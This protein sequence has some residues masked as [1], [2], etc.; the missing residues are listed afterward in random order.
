MAEKRQESGF[1]VTDRRL[2]TED[3]ELRKDVSEEAEAPKASAS[4]ASVPAP[5]EAAPA[6]SSVAPFPAQVDG[7]AERDMPLP[8]SAAEQQAQADAYH[9]S[10]KDLDSRVELSGRSAKELE[11]TF[12][13]FLASLYMTA[14]LQLGLMH[15]QG[16]QPRIDIIGAR[17]TIDT[18]SLLAD[19][20][21]G[22]LTPTEE[23]FLQN[24]LYEVRMAYVEVTNA[25]SRPPQPG[26][27]T[28]TSGR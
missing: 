21:K 4:P 16:G 8:P 23:T 5:K 12:E 1:T 19:K 2:F 6:P 3:G 17:Q 28:G 7:V 13:R 26:T 10:S 14:M 11:M 22:N 25:L 15:E 18:L 20:T 24:S 27:A 9:A